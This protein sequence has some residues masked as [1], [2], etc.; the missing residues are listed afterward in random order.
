ML[1]RCAQAVGRQSLE[2]G[3]GNAPLPIGID[4]ELANESQTLDQERMLRAAGA[5]GGWRNHAIQLVD[6][7][8][9]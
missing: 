4:A 8:G 2:S 6:A 7:S 1:Y 9:F 3:G 5:C